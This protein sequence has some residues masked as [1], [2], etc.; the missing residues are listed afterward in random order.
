MKYNGASGFKIQ[1]III[2]LINSLDFITKSGQFAP[3]SS[4]GGLLDFKF[5][6]T[7]AKI[8]IPQ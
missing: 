1:K 5:N 2:F 8:F 4:S 3:K 6:R 7:M